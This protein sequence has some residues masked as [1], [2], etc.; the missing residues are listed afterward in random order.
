[1][2]APP[3]AAKKTAV[4]TEPTPVQVM[5]ELQAEA[6]KEAQDTQKDS[7]KNGKPVPVAAPLNL[8]P[9]N[10]KKKRFAAALT[11]FTW[12]VKRQLEPK[13][14]TRTRIG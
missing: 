8:A 3:H 13:A 1:M 7:R 4:A 14:A 10:L 2:E 9:I 5:P 12:S 6:P 11:N